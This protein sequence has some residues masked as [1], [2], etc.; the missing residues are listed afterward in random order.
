LRQRGAHLL[1]CGKRRRKPVTTV[2]ELTDAELAELKNATR[3]AE[4]AAAVRA[5]MQEYLRHVRRVQLKALSGK[6]QMEDNWRTLEEAELRD[7]DERLRS[8]PH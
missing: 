2:V 4:P 5:A 1:Q 8:D 7:Q 3:Q 6:V